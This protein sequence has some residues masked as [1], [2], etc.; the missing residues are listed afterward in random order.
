MEFAIRYWLSIAGAAIEAYW[1]PALL[2]V[3]FGYICYRMGKRPEE[4][5]AHD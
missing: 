2:L 1:F 5:S 4:D 3:A